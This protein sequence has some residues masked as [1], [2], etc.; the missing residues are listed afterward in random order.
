MK[1]IVCLGFA[2]SCWYNSFS[3]SEEI[4][5]LFLNSYKVYES[6][7][8]E[9][10]IYRDSKLF[11]GEDFHP[12][13]VANI[14]IGLIALCIADKMGWIRDAEEK[15]ITTLKSISGQNLPFFPDRNASGF[16]RHFIDMNSGAQMWESEY[17]TIDTGILTVGALFSKRYFSDNEE[18]KLLADSLWES[19]DWSKSIADASRGAIYREMAVNG[20]GI[21]G[22]LT[23]PFNEYMIVAYLAKNQE[24][25][26]LGPA[27]QLWEKFYASPKNLPSIEF[28][29]I[30]L[31]TDHPSNYLSNFVI[32]FA[33]YLCHPFSQNEEYLQYFE[34]ALQTDK[35]WWDSKNLSKTYQW[36]LG[37]GSCPIPEGY[38]VS[39]IND[40]PYLVH[41]PHI[42]AGFIPIF[43]EAK[44]DLI[45][46]YKEGSSIYILP[47][48]SQS[49]ILWRK[50]FLDSTWEA[51]DIQGIDFS[52]MLMGLA[53]LDEHLGDRFFPC[54]NNFFE[55]TAC[56]LS[57]T[58]NPQL[59]KGINFSVITNSDQRSS[60]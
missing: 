20:E 21:P 9:L 30:Q 58:S 52:S 13:S 23:L 26:E 8:N 6:Q 45:D 49:E 15:V 34:N 18:I 25:E 12:A 24:E 2:L 22:T 51:T 54:Y 29:G 55:E 1:N 44:D 17:S 31:L 59:I 41:A 27:H 46:L 38:C 32:Q 43:P 7:R 35:L 50:S 4:T 57:T 40:N 10:G 42:M 5:K 53:T 16:F 56:S 33:Y 60:V 3:Q 28:E 39:S 47:D 19:I 14:G 37:A 11:E 48:S 36:G